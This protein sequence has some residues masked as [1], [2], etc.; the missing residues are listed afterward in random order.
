MLFT[1]TLLISSNNK[2]YNVGMIP[3][4]LLV[5][6]AKPRDTKHDVGIIYIQYFHN[7]YI[8]MAQGVT[9]GN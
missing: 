3:K 8:F 1:S 4:V 6:E 5:P 2:F 9:E 7:K